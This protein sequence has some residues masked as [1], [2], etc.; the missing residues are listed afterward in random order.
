MGLFLFFILSHQFFI[1]GGVRPFYNG[2]VFGQQFLYGGASPADSQSC[3]RLMQKSTRRIST[4][5]VYFRQ[6]ILVAQRA[7]P[8][9][10]Q[11]QTH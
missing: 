4:F 10:A 7:F 3:W 11:M 5:F 9:F 1:L 2:V 8:I 6:Q